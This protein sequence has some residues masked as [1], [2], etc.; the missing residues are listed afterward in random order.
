MFSNGA[1]AKIWKIVN[2]SAKYVD[3]NISTSSKDKLT[4]KYSSD[5][6]GYARFIGKAFSI[7]YEEGM[8]V[9]LISVG[10][11]QKYDKVTQKKYTNFLVFD[12]EIAEKNGE[13][14]KPAQTKSPFDTPNNIENEDEQLPF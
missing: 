8:S 13:T 7:N 12:A 4:G 1:Y 3:L 9:K 6:S 5:F 10:V 11:T 2:K 14:P